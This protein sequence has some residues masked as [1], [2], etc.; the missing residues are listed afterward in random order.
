MKKLREF[1]VSFDPI[2][3][4][5]KKRGIEFWHSHL[6]E[7]KILQQQKYLNLKNPYDQIKKFVEEKKNIKSYEKYEINWKFLEPS[8]SASQTSR[9]ELLDTISSIQDPSKQKEA[10][11]H[12]YFDKTNF[13][14]FKSVLKSIFNINNLQELQDVVKC[15][16]TMREVENALSIASTKKLEADKQGSK[17]DPTFTRIDKKGKQ[18]VDSKTDKTLFIDDFE[19]I[20]ELQ[21]DPKR[22]VADWMIDGNYDHD[23]RRC[24]PNAAVEYDEKDKYGWQTGDEKFASRYRQDTV[25][26]VPV[27]F[28]QQ[29]VFEQEDHAENCTLKICSCL[30]DVFKFGNSWYYKDFTQIQYETTND[31]QFYYK[32]QKLE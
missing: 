18:F 4:D 11:K 30:F 6:E 20:G 29:M 1:Y 22:C 24:K 15:G 7:L 31:F 14:L 16:S 3:D 19:G 2:N 21:L 25:F 23:F 9:Q 28:N 27:K 12:V 10:L 13:N 17:T 5:N 32:D 26:G 8:S